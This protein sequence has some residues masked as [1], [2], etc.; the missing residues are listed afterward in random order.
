M[1]ASETRK[2]IR[3]NCS[4]ADALLAGFAQSCAL[5]GLARF[6]SRDQNFHHIS[7]AVLFGIDAA[8]DGHEILWEV[9][10]Q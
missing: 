8:G 6:A 5:R 3:E 2:V 4:L 1:R 10:E 9:V 7:P